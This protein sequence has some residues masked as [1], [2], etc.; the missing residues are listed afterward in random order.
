MAKHRNVQHCVYSRASVAYWNAFITNGK[1]NMLRNGTRNIL[2][3]YLHGMG[4]IG[5]QC[6]VYVGLNVMGPVAQMVGVTCLEALILYKVRCDN[7]LSHCGISRF[8]SPDNREKSIKYTYIMNSLIVVALCFASALAG[9][10][11]GYAHGRYAF[12]GRYGGKCLLN[13][14]QRGFS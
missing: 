4:L 2:Q 5:L 6:W 14:R 7:I 9:I 3:K 8:I 11:D 13:R 1:P 12:Y 10:P